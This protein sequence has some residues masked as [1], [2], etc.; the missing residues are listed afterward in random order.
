MPKTENGVHG[1]TMLAGIASAK[2]L[3]LAGINEGCQAALRGLT[4]TYPDM[5]LLTF[6]QQKREAETHLADATAECPLL[7]PLAEAR[8]IT[9][10][11]LAGRVL[12]KAAA[13]SAA[14]GALIGQRQR[15]EDALDAC[16]SVEEVQ[17]LAVNYSLPGGAA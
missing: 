10:D 17:A 3:K 15:M 6:D 4:A 5:E 11:D 7:S 14:S 13:F 8:G 1:A 2:A 16:T 12:A 9:L